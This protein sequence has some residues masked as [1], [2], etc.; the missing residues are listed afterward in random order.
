M[1]Y[2]G[3]DAKSDVVAKH[4]QKFKQ[5]ISKP[6]Y[7]KYPE[8]VRTPPEE[9]WRMAGNKFIRNIIYY[10]D[11]KA[12]AYVY[13][14]NSPENVPEN[15]QSDYN[16]IWHGGMPVEV[17]LKGLKP[18]DSW[19]QWQKLGLDAHSVIGDP[20]F[21]DPDKDDFRLKPDSPALKLG[22]KPIPIEQIGPYKD[23]LARQLADRPGPGRSGASHSARSPHG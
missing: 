23:P 17:E 14:P 3:H 21:V 5:A 20:L 12:K 22:F 15:N 4:L 13:Y 9:I 6:A 19:Q 7:A 2:S 18:Q 16:L 11:A 8:L 10:R 1:M